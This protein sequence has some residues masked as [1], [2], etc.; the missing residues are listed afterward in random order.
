MEYRKLCAASALKVEMVSFLQQKWQL[1]ELG[2]MTSEIEAAIYWFAH[3]YQEELPEAH[4]ILT[5]SFHISTQV[6]ESPASDNIKWPGTVVPEMYNDLIAEFG[7]YSGESGSVL[8]DEI[9]EEIS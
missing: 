9:E 4:D 5:T 7:R 6:E 2:D 8:N 3:D 1:E